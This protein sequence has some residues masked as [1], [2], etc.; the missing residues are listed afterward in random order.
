LFIQKA[1]QKQ[2]LF[3]DRHRLVIIAGAGQVYQLALS[4]DADTWVLRLDQRPLL[5]N[6]P[7]WLFFNQSISIFN[8]PIS[9]Y[10]DATNASSVRSRRSRPPE[11]PVWISSNACFFHWVIWVGWTPY[12]AANSLIVFCPLIASTATFVFSSELYR[13]R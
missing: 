3:T 5:L 1:H 12:S 11:N 9:W 13:F 8:C 6:A 10:S 4:C 2:I 7:D